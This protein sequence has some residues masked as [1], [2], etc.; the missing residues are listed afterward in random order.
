MSDRVADLITRTKT[1]VLER[2]IQTQPVSDFVSGGVTE[3]IGDGVATRQRFIQN[4][5]AIANLI[6]TGERESR[7]TQNECRP[8]SGFEVIDVTE[9]RPR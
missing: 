1:T 9:G 7:P 6:D 8:I 3:V 2:V 5:Y 4:H